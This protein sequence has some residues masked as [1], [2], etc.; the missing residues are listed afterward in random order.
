MWVVQKKI[1]NQW[2]DATIKFE[3]EGDAG[4]AYIMLIERPGINEDDY[5]V[6]FTSG[7]G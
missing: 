5:R 3:D 1:N 4:N 2:V 6:K 7:R